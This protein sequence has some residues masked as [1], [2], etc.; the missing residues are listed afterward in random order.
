MKAV[1]ISKIEHN[2]HEG[3]EYTVEKVLYT[4]KRGK[5]KCFEEMGRL[6]IFDEQLGA[7]RRHFTSKCF[8]Q[9]RSM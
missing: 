5:E 9:M 1:F 6:S 2:I 8:L 7:E 4:E 3:D